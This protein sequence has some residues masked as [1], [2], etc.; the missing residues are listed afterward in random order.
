MKKTITRSLIFS[1]LLKG[2]TVFAS[3]ENGPQPPPCTLSVSAGADKT[4]CDG[5][6]TQLVATPSGGTAPYTYSWTGGSLSNT[7]KQK[8]VASP[9]NGGTTVSTNTYIVTVTDANGCTGSDTVNIYVVPGTPLMSNGD[10]ENVGTPPD[11]RGQIEKSAA[12]TKATGDADLFYTGYDGCNIN[13]VIREIGL[14]NTS[15]LDYNCVGIPCNHFGYQD[16]SKPNTYYY[17]GL[18]AGIGKVALRSTDPVIDEEVNVAVEA[19]AIPITN[20]VVGGTYKLSF[21]VVRAEKGEVDNFG[22]TPYASYKIKMSDGSAVVT[23]SNFQPVAA[24]EIVKGD[25]SNILNWQHVEYVFTADK[26]YNTLYV[27]SYIDSLL[28]YNFYKDNPIDLD[29]DYVRLS[30]LESYI[31]IDDIELKFDCIADTIVVADA[32]P[33]VSVCSGTLI[34]IGGSPVAAGGTAP[35]TYYWTGPGGFSSTLPNPS[36][37][38]YYSG[39]YTVYVTDANGIIETDNMVVNVS[40]IYFDAGAPTYTQCPGVPT[41]IGGN[42]TGGIAPYTYNWTPNQ[43]IS[44][45]TV[46][47]PTVTPTQ[48]VTYTATVTDAAGCVRTD[49]V[50][51]IILS[52][53]SANAGNDTAVCQGASVTLKGT[54]SAPGTYIYRWNGVTSDSTIVVS[55]NSTTTYVFEAENERGCMIRDTIVVTVNQRPVLVVPNKEICPGFSTVIGSPATGGT[56]PYTYFWSGGLPNQAQHTVSPASTTGYT[57]YARDSKNCNSD[58]A[59]LTV[60]VNPVPV[61]NAGRDRIIC[62]GGNTQIGAT[63]VASGDAGWGY[64]W[65]AT[66][67]ISPYFLNSTTVARPIANPPS[68]TTYVVTV[69]NYY[70][71]T[72]RDTMRLTVNPGCSGGGEGG[73]GGSG[74]CLNLA[75]PNADAGGDRFVCSGTTLSLGGAPTA[76]GGLA[77]YTYS[78]TGPSFTS[79]ASNPS[80]SFTNDKRVYR[81]VVTDAC[82]RSSDDYTT[83]SMKTPSIPPTP[84]ATV[85]AGTSFQ[86]GQPATGGVI[87]GS[88]N[89]SWT[90]STGILPSGTPRGTVA[91]TTSTTYVLSATDFYNCTARDTIVITTNP[92]PSVNAG[93]DK[94]ICTA[95]PPVSIGHKAT[96]GTP[97]YTYKWLPV[98]GLNSLTDSV[99]L[100]NPYVTTEY[101]VKVT[102]SKGCT[103]SDMVTVFVSES[104]YIN[105]GPPITMCQG[106][107]RYMGNPASKGTPPYTYQWTPTTGLGNPTNY[108]TSVSPSS[109]TT[110]TLRVTDAN[111]CSKDTTV[112]VTVNPTPVADAGPDLA[113]CAGNSVSIGNPATISGPATLYYSWY[114]GSGLSNAYT[115]P[116]TATPMYTTN[117]RLYVYTE[118]GCSDYDDMNIQVYQT[119]EYVPNNSFEYGSQAVTGRGQIDRAEP[120]FASTGDPDLF[121]Y[122]FTGCNPLLDTLLGTCGNTPLDYNCVGIPCNH[123]GYQDARNYQYRYSGLFSA[124][125]VHVADRTMVNSTNV[126]SMDENMLTEGMEVKLEKPLT[127]GRQY[128]FSMWVNKAEKGETGGNLPSGTPYGADSAVVAK[129][130]PFSVKLSTDRVLG[131]NFQAVNRPTIVYGLVGDET[132]W[133]QVNAT[134]TAWEASEYLIIESNPDIIRYVT[135]RNNDTYYDVQTN[136]GPS[137]NGDIS[138]QTFNAV[139]GF[140]TA[141]PLAG[142]HDLQSYL[143][144]DDVSIIEVCNDV[145]P[146]VVDAGPDTTICTGYSTTIGGNPSASYGTPGYTY[147]W[148]AISPVSGVLGTTPTIT[149]SPTITTTYQLTV[150]DAG[151]QVE[152]DQVTVNVVNQ[153]PYVI[154]GGFES[155][156]EP[157]LRGDIERAPKWFKA[158]GDADLYD[159]T[160]SCYPIPN[161][162]T[163][164]N[165]NCLDIPVNHFG[166]QNVRNTGERYAGLWSLIQLS[167]ATT[168]AANPRGP[169]GIPGGEAGNVVGNVAGGAVKGTE[170]TVDVK[171]EPVNSTYTTQVA[172]EGIEIRLDKQLE[173][174]RYYTLS[175]YIS[176]AELGETGDNIEQL[177]SVGDDIDT[178]HILVDSCAGYHVKFSTD[179]VTNTLFR[180]VDRDIAHSGEVCDT[181]RWVY[182]YYTFKPT[183]NYNYLV[184]ESYPTDGVANYFAG[185]SSGTNNQTAQKNEISGFQSYFYIDDVQLTESCSGRPG[186]GSE[187]S[188]KPGGNY[189]D[190]MIEKVGLGTEPTVAKNNLVSSVKPNKSMLNEGLSLQVVPNPNTGSFVLN[191][192]LGNSSDLRA[193]II[194]TDAVGK[195]MYRFSPENTHA[196]KQSLEINFKAL[197]GQVNAGIYFARMVC[198]T[199]SL[200]KKITV[201]H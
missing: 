171:P 177:P 19:M 67:G 66:T 38:A 37:S 124:F 61:A 102:D 84:D 12:W 121:D 157:M 108:F 33:D 10:F 158:T 184:I 51:F 76:S 183:A 126:I 187:L 169:E 48:N 21:N 127:P 63:H 139:F 71:C 165:L 142:T 3:S 5:S 149:V 62:L 57:V 112:V 115:S 26:A 49:N 106:D 138:T 58:V 120:W 80:I 43:K 97:N 86:I 74:A 145:P 147:S 164:A 198:G 128:T 94:S 96:G 75:P 143:Y 2:F 152:S 56:A 195:E 156:T 87:R 163:P 168:V 160:Y 116:T 162:L 45:T 8:P 132:N 125:S 88:Y 179:S 113:I 44:S 189:I 9:S 190:N 193:E 15:P 54:M 18:W 77:P 60:T 79:S 99:V 170:V 104:P 201:I 141:A 135:I 107:V 39:T 109:T 191:Y 151:T 105:A 150:S 16:V 118:K 166:Y 32:G 41:V 140:D 65:V 24:D 136:P 35:Y 101:T 199:Q 200:V 175:F 53:P 42:A 68:T 11:G 167:E 29:G 130:A 47:M 1:L 40:N 148:A 70:G 30:G 82:G 64:S 182:H 197:N 55:P 14:C 117:Y 13:A 133:V 123:F 27:E 174:D 134:F 31:Y 17:A 23:S 46:A 69:T 185:H 72:A 92:I 95:N 119:P 73:S 78:W 129:R 28:T 173:T 89:Y 7:T 22:V 25:V 6:N 100:A 93:P 34:T 194:I 154:N 188:Q 131:E 192:S 90:A 144:I 155:G 85:C 178:K 36:F 146:L 137:A 122:S 50:Q 52:T 111:G 4:I 81:V 172:V 103:A 181:A 196:G 110:Y 91:P 114:P 153:S 180:P 186:S 20:L 176:K 98:R 159:S 83:V 161:D 59:S